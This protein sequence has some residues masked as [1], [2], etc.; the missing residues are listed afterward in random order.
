MRHA[1]RLV[2]CFLGVALLTL[3][4]FAADVP[5]EILTAA[6][7]AAGGTAWD[8][9][10][11]FRVQASIETSG[12]QGNVESWEELSGGRTTTRAT[13]G[14]LKVAS[15]FDGST[16]WNQ[17][18][19]G[20]VTEQGSEEDLL[21]A[22]NQAF[23][24]CRGY[25]FPQ[26]HSSKILSSSTRVDDGRTFDVIEILPQRGRRLE[27]WFDAETHLL[28]KTVDV[29]SEPTTTTYLTDY[30]QVENL[31]LPHG[32]RNSNGDTRYDTLIQVQ[33]IEINPE[34]DHSVFEVPR[35]KVDDFVIA[36]GA[37]SLTLPFELLNN[38]IYV[39]AVVD[40][41][42]PGRFLVDT[43][44]VNL[45][46][47]DAAARFGISSEGA[48]QGRGVGEK[49]V[50][51]SLAT[52][53][54]FTFG[55]ATL[56]NPTFYVIPLSEVEAAEGVDFDG[57]IGFE[58][59]KRFV[60]EI[61]YAA[62]TLTLTRP[63]AFRYAGNGT[64]VPFTFNDRTPIVQGSVASI[65]ATFSVDTGSRST[66]DL[67][68]PFV[69]EH[70]LEKTLG[71]RFEALSGWGVGG[72]VRSK[73]CPGTTLHLGDIV[74]PGVITA[75][76]QQKDGA[77]TDRYVAGNIGGGVL[78][79]FTVT[80]DYTNKTMILEAN[81][82]FK[83]PDLYDQSGMWLNRADGGFVVADVTE[84]GAA[85]T[86]G[87]QVG[88]RIVA[89]DGTGATEVRLPTLREAFRTRPTG[90]SIELTVES[91]SGQRDIKLVLKDLLAK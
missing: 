86:A 21:G 61:D 48:I 64:T 62:R 85:A 46:T 34:F 17:D 56:H 42:Q 10:T 31:M 66:L 58:V 81:T 52:L 69:A 6:K 83:N 43:G 63:E 89:C 54:S 25:W 29:E 67:F 30:R 40:S 57:L 82:D 91:S 41:D 71:P 24:S 38:H 3:P 22:N 84:D 33:T 72:G 53:E 45:L 27:L 75:L 70:G 49:T 12:F 20:D 59:F 51:V 18:P 65:P 68:G 39:E 7:Q 50:D 80:F 44:G 78:K 74:I 90:S 15:G 2:P 36:D 14:A 1:M 32:I 55:A 79:R 35:V 28:G 4:A 8:E 16:P 23:L 5:Q 87:I 73:I 60:V 88:D 76:S 77:F 13:L 47:A 37:T 9:V 26:R 19:S 11:H